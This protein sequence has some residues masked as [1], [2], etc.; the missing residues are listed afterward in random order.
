MSISVK[1]FLHGGNHRLPCPVHKH[2]YIYRREACLLYYLVIVKL[3]EKSHFHHLA[4]IF[5]K[6]VHSP[7][8]NPE[9]LPVY[10]HSVSSR[11]DTELLQPVF[12]HGFHILA[13]PSRTAEPDTV[14]TDVPDTEENKEKYLDYIA[15]QEEVERKRMKS[16]YET[17]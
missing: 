8:E 7:A 2:P 12:L 15:N 3:P 13:L 14:Y 17:E 10:H 1:I 6:T 16:K 4:L 5:R 9:H 11:L